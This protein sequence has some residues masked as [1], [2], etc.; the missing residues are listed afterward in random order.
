MGDGGCFS[1]FPSKNLGGYGDGGMVV[2]ND[3]DT[4]EKIRI[5][6]VH[7]CRKKYYHLIDGFNSRLDTIQAAI[8]RVKLKYLDDWND[9]RR[10]NARLYHKLLEKTGVILPLEAEYNK[11]VFYLYTIRVSNREELQ[12]ALKAEGVGNA[13]YYPVPLHLQEVYRDMGCKRGDFPVSEM[14]SDEVLS[15]PMYPEL[16][17]EQI[18][19]VAKAV[20]ESL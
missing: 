17:D 1:F 15:L 9:R 2:T 3:E 10:G 12:A 6:R 13:I 7:G 19:K 14:H 4:A 20:K 11:H 5:L 18:R 8:L 16:S